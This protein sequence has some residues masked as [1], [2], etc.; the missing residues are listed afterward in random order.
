MDA[1]ER[2]RRDVFVGCHSRVWQKLQGRLLPRLP[3]ICAI[4]HCDIGDFGFTSDDRVWILSYS[5]R[6]SDNAALIATLARTPAREIV[7]VSSSST[8]VNLRTACYDYPR[9]KQLAE[10]AA[11]ELPQARVL[12]LGLMYEEAAE[13]PGGTNIATSYD[14]LAAFV[15][16]PVWNPGPARQ[17]RLFRVVQRPVDRAWHRVAQAIYGALIWAAGP[18]PCV[19]RPLD[20]LL[21]AAG[22][23]NY[24][25]TYL[26]QRLW[27]STIS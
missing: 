19:L 11:L 27:T 20:L 7:Y 5:R 21:R 2:C 8:I 16:Q 15:A 24:G 12:T 9:L 18:W 4:G 23:R 10:R 17:Q 26:S 14:E 1:A 3:G 6:T 25:Y 22:A 13:L